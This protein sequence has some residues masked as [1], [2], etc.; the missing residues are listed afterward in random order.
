[1]DGVPNRWEFWIVEMPE[2]SLV[3]FGEWGDMPSY[4]SLRVTMGDLVLAGT[5]QNGCG[6]FYWCPTT[7]SGIPQCF[8]CQDPFPAWRVARSAARTRECPAAP[9]ATL[10]RRGDLSAATVPPYRRGDA[11]GSPLGHANWRP[12]TLSRRRHLFAIAAMLAAV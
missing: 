3:W 8:N 2:V 4:P 5:Q 6:G 7:Q 12:A 9:A 11:G 10:R 1:F